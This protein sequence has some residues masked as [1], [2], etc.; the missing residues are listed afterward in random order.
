MRNPLL[1]CFATAA[2]LFA[3]EPTPPANPPPPSERQPLLV[4][5]IVA[6]VN[7][8]TIMWSD[9]RTAAA[10]RKRAAETNRG[11]PLSPADIAAIY[12]LT[13][14]DLID[15]HS[16]AQAAKTFGVVTP[17]QVEDLFKSEMDREKKDMERTM[18]GAQK[19]LEELHRQGRTWQTY[20]SEQRV[21]K[22]ADFAREFSITMRMQKQGNLFLTPRMLRETYER[23]QR[24]QQVFD[25]GARALVALVVFSG[26]DAQQNAAR[27]AEVWRQEDLTSRQLAARFP[28]ATGLED[29]LANTLRPELEQFALAGPLHA[30]SAP[31]AAGETLQLAKVV[32]YAPERHGRFEDH[33][34]QEQL[35]AICLQ[36][37]RREF[38]EQA[39]RRA[40]QRTEVWVSPR[41]R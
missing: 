34:V 41:F 7:D 40:R 16:M 29:R 33:D 13:L 14:A 21:E 6:T 17:E 27:A 32:D 20:V 36:G 3:Q 15:R 28:G 26:P 5:Q 38:E 18:G 30:V 22:M 1:A 39:L 19:F 8:S 24:E 10:G 37:V 23:L 9:L 35:R 25:H 12:R 2:T 31:F 11:Q 4:D